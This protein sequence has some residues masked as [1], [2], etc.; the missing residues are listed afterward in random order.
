MYLRFYVTCS[1]VATK[2]AYNLPSEVGSKIISTRTE[3]S[4]KKHPRI[5]DRN[6]SITS[7]KAF[8]LSA[9]LNYPTV[10]WAEI[11]T[12]CIK[13]FVDYV[14]KHLNLS[15]ADIFAIVERGLNRTEAIAIATMQNLND[16]SSVTMWSGGRA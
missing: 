1:L 14:L 15:E 2:H 12:F 4:Y 11:L 13:M 7:I 5:I 6:S 8:F 3:V 10:T 9:S 16:W